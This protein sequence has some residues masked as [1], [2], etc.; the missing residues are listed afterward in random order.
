[1]KKQMKMMMS[2]I[3]ALAA[4]MFVVGCGAKA[5]Q[6]EQPKSQPPRSIAELDRVNGF[7]VN[8]LGSENK[9]PWGESYHVIRVNPGSSEKM[10]SLTTEGYDAYDGEYQSAVVT[11]ATASIGGSFKTFVRVLNFNEVGP[12]DLRNRFL[13]DEVNGYVGDSDTARKMAHRWVISLVGNG[14]QGFAFKTALGKQKSYNI[15]EVE[16]RFVVLSLLDA[17]GDKPTR[18]M[19]PTQ[20][21][22]EVDTNTV[23]RTIHM[24]APPRQ[25]APP[26]Q[27]FYKDGTPKAP[28]KPNAKKVKEAPAPP[29]KPAASK[30]E[31]ERKLSVHF[32]HEFRVNPVDIAVKA[33]NVV[34]VVSEPVQLVGPAQPTT[35]VNQK[36]VSVG[37][38]APAISSN[39]REVKQRTGK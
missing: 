2:I 23:A 15:L 35:I 38:V 28:A 36:S 22:I 12:A 24:P 3:A 33:S 6:P 9:L 8:Q 39:D 26:K 14:K 11:G 25:A 7:A 17:S 4:V 20:E 10:V 29:A 37:L 31:P 5:P 1:M 18:L 34:H 30:Q 32:T 21:F 13:Q 27:E 19:D 16:G